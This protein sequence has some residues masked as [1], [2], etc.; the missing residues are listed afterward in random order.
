M[1][2]YEKQINCLK[3]KETDLE[4]NIHEKSALCNKQILDLNNKDLIIKKI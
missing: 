4:N 1:T 3:E 2:K